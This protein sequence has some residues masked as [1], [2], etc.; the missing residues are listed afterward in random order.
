MTNNNKP[1]PFRR[2][3]DSLVPY[4]TLPPPT[5]A[6]I[7]LRFRVLNCDTPEIVHRVV[8]IPLSYTFA[9]LYYL[10]LFLFGWTGNHV[11]EA[12][13]YSHVET[14]KGGAN[15]N[16]NTG[17]MKKY[18]R[19]PPV[20]DW[21][22]DSRMWEREEGSSALYQ[23]VRQGESRWSHHEWYNAEWVPRVEDADCTIGQ[24]WNENPAHN[25]SRGK[26]ANDAIGVLY[27]YNMALGGMSVL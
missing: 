16:A 10:M 13:V 11:H 2:A 4:K 14:Y 23:V 1:R 12:S 25:A 22:T 5:D 15:N 27:E 7:Q 26:C 8:R 24:V 3:V 6:Y 19:T 17:V 21:C 9:N 20:P 18:G